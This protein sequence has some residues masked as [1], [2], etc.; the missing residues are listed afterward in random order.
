MPLFPMTRDDLLRVRFSVSPILETVLSLRV[1]RG[2][3]TARF[4][5]P[6]VRQV[7]ADLDPVALQPLLALVPSTGFIADAV[8]PL[9]RGDEPMSD[10]MHL[11]SEAPEEVWEHDLDQLSRTAGS[12]QVRE[13]L[14][15]MRGRAGRERV[16][17]LLLDYHS[18]AIAP[19]WH[20]LRALD[21]ADI[22]WRGEALS[23]GGIERV[24][25]DLHPMVELQPEGVLVKNATCTQA[26]PVAGSGLVLAPCVFAWP[27]AISLFN[28]AYAPV[29]SY[30]PRGIARLWSGTDHGD[31]GGLARLVGATR[32]EILAQLDIPLSTSQVAC[33]MEI[34]PATA[35]EHLRVLLEAKLAQT[36]R[37]GRQVLYRRTQ[38]GD[39]LVGSTNT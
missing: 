15:S 9:V 6:W 14:A 36:S 4:H 2:G 38:I 13:V 28:H 10:L 37:D 26:G 8:T 20:R 3:E 1:L 5:A 39:Q 7:R 35:N 21:L 27:R 18:V 12:D 17:G 11:M 33:A 16:A 34:A 31:G 32:A 23:T 19:H 30:F 29:I 22:A 25:A 24:F